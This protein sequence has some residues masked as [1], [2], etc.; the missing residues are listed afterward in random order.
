MG[1]IKLS[2][3]N[4]LK[5]ENYPKI[6]NEVNN[7][8][9]SDINEGKLRVTDINLNI[10][11]P[12]PDS[13]VLSF[14]EANNGLKLVLSNISAEASCKWKKKGVIKIKGKGH[15]K[16]TFDRIEL[17]LGLGTQEKDGQLVPSVYAKSV[18]VDMDKHK[19]KGDFGHKNIL[20]KIGN[21]LLNLFRGKGV[22]F[23]RKKITDQLNGKVPEM[24]NKEIKKK[25]K[26]EGPISPQ[27]SISTALTGPIVVNKDYLS[28]PI[29]GT[30]FVTEKG[31]K[32]PFNAG[33]IPLMP[34][35]NQ[36]DI[37]LTATDYSFKTLED[38]LNQ[39]E[40]EYETEYGGFKAM[41]VVGGKKDSFNITNISNGLHVTANAV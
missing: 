38:S 5:D 41:I 27:L 24:I 12:S 6:V 3:L 14:D 19:W 13:I 10:N 37:I 22:K 30:V 16:G 8:H 39:L 29:D 17:V 40:F 35:S 4:K 28:V 26:V 7:I 9:I 18:K 32:R 33:G 31:F 36:S 1:A 25:F 23:I 11:I 20:S 21:G 2:F 34:I 15:L